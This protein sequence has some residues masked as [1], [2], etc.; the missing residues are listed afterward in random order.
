MSDA[1]FIEFSDDN[2]VSII[3]IQINPMIFSYNPFFKQSFRFSFDLSFWAYD[4]VSISINI[5]VQL[6][7]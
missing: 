6:K 5:F 2:F 3:S 1:Y 4:F 7:L